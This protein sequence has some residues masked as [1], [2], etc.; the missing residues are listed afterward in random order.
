MLTPSTTPG[1][2]VPTL[3]VFTS[4][5]TISVASAAISAFVSQQ[6]AIVLLTD[7]SGG[8]VSD[9]LAAVTGSYVE[10]TMEN[11]VA[12]LAGKVN[13]LC[14]AANGRGGSVKPIDGSATAADLY[15]NLNVATD[16]DID[17]DATVK[18]NG[19]LVLEWSNAGGFAFPTT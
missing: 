8:T 14:A 17:A 4:S 19:T 9:T 1:A 10:A 15:L 11:I 16:G 3:P 13:Q 18:I 2:C 7:S 12:S 6:T 5:A